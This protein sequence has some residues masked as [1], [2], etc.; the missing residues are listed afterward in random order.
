MSHGTDWLAGRDEHE[1]AWA[2]DVLHERGLRACPKCG[3][4]GPAY[5][6]CFGCEQ[7]AW[8]VQEGKQMTTTTRPLWLVTVTYSRSSGWAVYKDGKR[9]S[10]Y[11]GTGRAALEHA[12]ERGWQVGYRG[13]TYNEGGYLNGVRAAEGK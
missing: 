4:D 2:M 12:I 5:W 1:Q 6:G 13:M 11:F 7:I 3:Y 8:R 9:I 10:A